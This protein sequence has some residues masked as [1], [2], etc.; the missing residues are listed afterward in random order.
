M[1]NGR[2]ALYIKIHQSEVFCDVVQGDYMAS[3][4]ELW[5]LK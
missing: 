3:K 4:A 2:G 1:A 5:L